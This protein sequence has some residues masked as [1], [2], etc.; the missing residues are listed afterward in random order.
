MGG[1]RL[2]ALAAEETA[3]VKTKALPS[4]EQPSEKPEATATVLWRI[5][6]ASCLMSALPLESAIP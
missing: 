1:G 3:G 2:S 5:F 6:G 4:N